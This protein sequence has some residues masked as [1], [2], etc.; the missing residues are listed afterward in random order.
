MGGK[1]S[2]SNSSI[3]ELSSPHYGLLTTIIRSIRTFV[4]MTAFAWFMMMGMSRPYA[5]Q[6]FLAL[7]EL[8]PPSST[9]GGVIL[10]V[11]FPCYQGITL[12]QMS[13]PMIRV[14]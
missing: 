10:H 9:I 7:G 2:I 11:G 13:T 4:P 1:F 14:T 3:M 8:C 12:G 5:E 6:R